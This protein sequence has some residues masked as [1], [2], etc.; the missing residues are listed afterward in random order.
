[1]FLTIAI[2]KRTDANGNEYS[3]EFIDKYGIPSWTVHGDAAG[4]PS[5]FPMWDKNDD[6][7]IRN[8][9]SFDR[10]APALQVSHTL[11][12]HLR[13]VRLHYGLDFQEL[14]AIGKRSVQIQQNLKR[15]RANSTGK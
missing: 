7:T 14:E 5:V 3:P 10:L 13:A 11:F 8:P 6:W 4:I 12:D 15:E 2:D 1:M 9:D